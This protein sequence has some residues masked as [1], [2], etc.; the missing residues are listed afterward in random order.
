MYLLKDDKLPLAKYLLKEYN[1][2]TTEVLMKEMILSLAKSNEDSNKNV[3][4]KL[5]K[6]YSEGH[7][8]IWKGYQENLSLLFMWIVQVTVRYLKLF[9][10]KN[11]KND[12]IIKVLKPIEKYE[13]FIEKIIKEQNKPGQEKK[14]KRI[15]VINHKIANG[16]EAFFSPKN[17][18]YIG[19]LNETQW[20]KLISISK[21]VDKA[22]VDFVSGLKDN[23]LRIIINNDDAKK[24]LW[25]MIQNL[26]THNVFHRGKISQILDSLGIENDFSGIGKQVL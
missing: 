8:N 14:G 1:I 3:I 2:K 22:F 12:N 26:S 19:Q 13:K 24:A 10:N 4:R 21:I 9:E 23:D 11:P 17:G 5:G 15:A 25:L 18:L 20:K 16:K 6:L 7:E